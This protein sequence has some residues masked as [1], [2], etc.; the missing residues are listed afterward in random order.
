MNWIK[1]YRKIF[2]ILGLLVFVCAFTA[3]QAPNSFLS[4]GNL[5]NTFR[6]TALFGIISV[7]VAFVIITGGIDLSI[8][9]VIG[10]T[11]CVLAMSMATTYTPIGEAAI[12]E[13]DQARNRLTLSRPVSEQIY[14]VGAQIKVEDQ[15]L[16][17][18]S[19]EGDQLTVAEPIELTSKQIEEAPR[20][21]PIKL[22]RLIQPGPLGPTLDQQVEVGNKL[23]DVREL[24]LEGEFPELSSKDRVTLLYEVGLAKEKPIHTATVAD[25]Q[26]T[27]R[28]LT[29]R[30]ERIRS[31]NVVALSFRS[32]VMP[33][34][35][36]MLLVLG[37]SCLIGLIHGL[38]IT[39]LKLQPFIVTLCGLLFYRG[40][41]RY[42]TKDGEQGFQLE[43]LDL[44]Q[45][46]KGSLLQQLTGSEYVFDIPMPFVY[47]ILLGIVAAVFLNKT[48]YGRY[49]LAL[50]RNEEAARYSG[51]NTDRMVVLSYVICSLCAGIAGI[52]FALNLN[53]ITPSAH[54]AF[55]ELYAIAAAVLGGC[56]LRGG[57]G[58]ILG[59]IIAAAVMQVLKNAINLIEWMDKSTEFAIIGIVILLGVIADE[60]AKRVAA[61]RKAAAQARA[62]S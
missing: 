39:R 5:Q 35:M 53:A 33:T 25:G 45:Q 32:Q 59:V 37:L 8:G 4:A 55:Y 44:K 58:S 6:W 2:G 7:G 36:A 23:N 24:T 9:S 47:L 57:E 49:M 3:W 19:V 60:L 10:L 15:W 34:G 13:V 38:L 43:Y 12:K 61:R 22:L 30:G 41:A 56:S 28:F 50:G 26:T 54:G 14:P 48:I 29:R 17:I 27:I 16:T 31:P 1:S 11:G 42:I 51:I 46:A 62:S 52:L 18:Q 40:V 21:A 20:N